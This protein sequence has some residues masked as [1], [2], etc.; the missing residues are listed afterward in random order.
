M[1]SNNEIHDNP[2]QSMAERRH[3]EHLRD[4]KFKDKEKYCRRIGKKLS[5][6]DRDKLNG[7]VTVKIVPSHGPQE[8]RI[9]IPR[10]TKSYC[11]IYKIT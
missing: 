4:V 2:E 9:V 3:A 1:Q 8:E 6:R 11:F 10:N 7:N 5:D